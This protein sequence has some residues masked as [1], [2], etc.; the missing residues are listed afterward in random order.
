MDL[1]EAIPEK[2]A[3]H[4]RAEL[5]RGELLMILLS[6]DIRADGQYGDSWF[7]LTDERLIVFQPKTGDEIDISHIALDQIEHIQVR[8]YVGS[9]ALLVELAN[10]TV[11]LVRF[12]PS[13]YFKFSSVPQAVEA[14]GIVEEE[15]I[16]QRAGAPI[17]P[18]QKSA[19]SAC[20]KPRPS[21]ACSP[22]SNPIRARL[23]LVL[24]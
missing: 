12:S 15:S 23:S 10:E 8:N 13:A 19:H 16:A 6:A 3:P 21:G 1:V 9:G 5:K 20:R 4:I 24:L 11:E 2:L 17:A 18:V 7:A 22:I 14:A